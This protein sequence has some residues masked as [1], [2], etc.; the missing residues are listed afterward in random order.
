[1]M[2]SRSVALS[3]DQYPGRFLHQLRLSSSSVA[4]YNERQTDNIRMFE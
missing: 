4:A 3:F 1:M 2:V